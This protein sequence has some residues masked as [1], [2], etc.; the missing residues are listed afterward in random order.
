MPEQH[1]RTRLLIQRLHQL[2]KLLAAIGAEVGSAQIKR[3]R[4]DI[5]RK[6]CNRSFRI[7]SRTQLLKAVDPRA[8]AG[9]MRDYEIMRARQH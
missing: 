4:I 5:A 7:A 8:L 3:H 2:L 9:V 1:H 6:A